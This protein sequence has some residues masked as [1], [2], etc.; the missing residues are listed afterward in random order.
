MRSEQRLAAASAWGR[1][2]DLTP[3]RASRVALV[4]PALWTSGF[5]KSGYNGPY[6]HIEE[7]TDMTPAK[8]APNLFEL[9]GKDVQ[10]VYSTSS[11]T[12]KPLLQYRGRPRDKSFAGQDIRTEQTEIGTLVTVT[13]EQVPDLRSVTLTFVLPAING[14][15]SAAAAISFKTNALLTTHRTSIG[16][17]ALVKGPLQT[18]QAVPLDGKARSVRF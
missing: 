7:S 14:E 2:H 12:G 3:F 15:G 8:T 11:V 10:I 18:Y 5:G 6:C 17:P 13:L 16:G 9:R 4:A 1:V